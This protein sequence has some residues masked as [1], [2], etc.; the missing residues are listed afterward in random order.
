MVINQWD[1]LHL[2]DHHDGCYHNDII[3]CAMNMAIS[4]DGVD[5]MIAH[6]WGRL[7]R[8]TG[9]QHQRHMDSNN[10][11]KQVNKP[12]NGTTCCAI[13]IRNKEMS[14]FGG[15]CRRLTFRFLREN[16]PQYWDAKQSIVGM[17]V[18]VTYD[19]IMHIIWPHQLLRNP[20][21]II[22]YSIPFIV[23]QFIGNTLIISVNRGQEP[24]YSR[25]E[26]VLVWSNFKSLWQR[27]SFSKSV[28]QYI[29]NSQL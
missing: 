15:Q 22:I 5:T 18:L 10:T 11:D 29:A 14:I 8:Y 28:D 23:N 2:C 3:M 7:N 21:I 25:C 12:D 9:T 4:K 26:T 20:L 17:C 6:A 16:I 24:N 13:I 27:V 1:R 19:D